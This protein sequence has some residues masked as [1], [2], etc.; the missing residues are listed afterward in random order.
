VPLPPRTGSDPPSARRDHEHNSQHAGET[1]RRNAGGLGE[2]NRLFELYLNLNVGCTHGRRHKPIPAGTKCE[3]CYAAALAD[4]TAE[5]EAETAGVVKN[6]GANVGEHK[7]AIDPS[8]AKCVCAGCGEHGDDMERHIVDDNPQSAFFKAFGLDPKSAYGIAF[9]RATEAAGFH[10]DALSR[11][12][13]SDIRSFVRFAL[14][15]R[16]RYRWAHRLSL[17]RCHCRGRR[18][19]LLGGW[20]WPDGRWGV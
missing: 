13:Y 16:C 9:I 11:K 6:R 12:P 7:G 1:L 15:R 5:I 17:L 10:F 2:F 4:A 3:Q 14:Q 18:R 20:L 19:A 8:G